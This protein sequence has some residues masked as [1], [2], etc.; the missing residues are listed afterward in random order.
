[1][2]LYNVSDN[3]RTHTHKHTLLK[4]RSRSFEEDDVSGCFLTSCVVQY[5][6]LCN[7]KS[8]CHEH[9]YICTHTCAHT[10]AMFNIY[11]QANS[12]KAV[13]MTQV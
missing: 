10:H 5:L 4:T 8:W 1:M 11:V 12:T 13:V 3:I 7:R 9:I 6:Y 2:C